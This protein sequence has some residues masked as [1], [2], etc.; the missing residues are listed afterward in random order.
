LTP[1]PPVTL[2]EQ[3]AAQVRQLI[4]EGNS[5]KQALKAA[6]ELWNDPQ[7]GD[8]AKALWKKKYPD[9][10]IPG[11]DETQRLQ[12]I[13]NKFEEDRANEKKEAELQRQT[14]EM[15]QQRNAVK[16]RR[17]YTDEAMKDMEK[18]MDEKRVY[19]YE[20]A[21][22]LFA[23]KNP[24]PSDGG[25]DFSTHFWEHDKQPAFKEIAADPEKWGFNEIVR[26]ARA[27]QQQRNKF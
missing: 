25:A 10:Q 20:A 7:L 22:L 13:V 14:A 6:Q 18:M 8:P 16:E 3:Q 17:G 5:A 2:T 27:D 26:A 11:Y 15:Q 9:S 12:G 19:D 24:R 21:D 4:E 23:A 1:V